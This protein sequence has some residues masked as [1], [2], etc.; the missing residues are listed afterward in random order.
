MLIPGP[1]LL[2]FLVQ[3]RNNEVLRS[4]RLPQDLSM[5]YAKASVDVLQY[6]VSDIIPAPSSFFSPG[7]VHHPLIAWYAR[8][9]SSSVHE[10]PSATPK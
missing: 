10:G 3:N 9:G 6:S 2:Y 8:R 1:R 4:A 5:G 7:S